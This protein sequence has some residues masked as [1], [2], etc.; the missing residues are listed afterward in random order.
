MGGGGDDDTERAAEEA[1]SGRVFARSMQE[2]E[3]KI[4]RRGSRKPRSLGEFTSRFTGETR[5]EVQ[6]RRWLS[7]RGEEKETAA[8]RRIDSRRERKV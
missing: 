1:H 3:A 6:E 8:D 7:E 2:E 4:R 5:H